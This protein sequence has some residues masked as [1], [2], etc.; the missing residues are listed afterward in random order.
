MAGV[1]DCKMPACSRGISSLLPYT[2]VPDAKVSGFYT[3][4]VPGRLAIREMSAS[5]TPAAVVTA[6]KLMTAVIN[7]DLSSFALHRRPTE[8]FDPD[9]ELYLEVAGR[10]GIEP[11]DLDPRGIDTVT[12]CS[13]R[14]FDARAANK[15]EFTRDRTLIERL[16]REGREVLYG[17]NRRK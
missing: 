5:D 13:S 10:N 4:A 17:A 6:F 16:A 9:W 11:S 2:P 14:E 7:Y 1:Q 8:S 12:A 3:G 15:D